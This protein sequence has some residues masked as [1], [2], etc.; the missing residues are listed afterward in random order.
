MT[1]VGQAQNVISGLENAAQKHEIDLVIDLG[2][3]RLLKWIGVYTILALAVVAKISDFVGPNLSCYPAG[4]SSGFD[5][6]FIEF[7]TTYCWESLASP[8][9]N[10]S[11]IT[12]NGTSQQCKYLENKNKINLLKNPSDM[13]LF[14]HWLPYCMLVQAILFA[15]P[16]AFWH[17]RV[18]A[19][20]LGH[21]KFMQLLI[22]DIFEKVKVI[23]LAFYEGNPYDERSEHLDGLRLNKPKKS[24]IGTP[25]KSAK[26][27]FGSSGTLQVASTALEISRKSSS[28]SL[29]EVIAQ[30]PHQDS[31]SIH[32]NTTND[33]ENNSEKI[34]LLVCKKI[35][36]AKE[37]TSKSQ[38]NT[39][40]A[41]TAPNSAEAKTTHE[42]ELTFYDKM[43]AGNMKD[44]HLFSMICYENFA[45]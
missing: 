1:T 29:Q 36:S 33:A 25:S 27:T 20:V 44:R 15:L 34:E 26:A 4:K 6:N 30:S 31:T 38:P 45:S 5:G 21:V 8:E 28:G 42:L 2:V 39:M 10:T 12:H 32:K 14:I 35:K 13:K 18:G 7:A 17:F 23:P 9:S 16:P 19:R 37:S 22:I 3:D 43:L 41:A 40:S 24:K 11:V